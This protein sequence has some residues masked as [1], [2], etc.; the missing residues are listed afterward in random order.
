MSSTQPFKLS[1]DNKEAREKVDTEGTVSIRIFRVE[2]GG[3]IVKDNITRSIRLEEAK[4]SDVHEYL[5]SVLD[6][7]NSED[8]SGE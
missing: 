3:K 5:M 2:Q 6:P 1:R 4:V 7:N 8:E